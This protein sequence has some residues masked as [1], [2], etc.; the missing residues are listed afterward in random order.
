[1]C[2]IITKNVVMYIWCIFESSTYLV[3]RVT[4]SSRRGDTY[5]VANDNFCSYKVTNSQN[6]WRST[7]LVT[8]CFSYR[9]WLT[10]SWWADQTPTV[11]KMLIDSCSPSVDQ[12]R[13][14]WLCPLNE[15]QAAMIGCSCLSLLMSRTP[16]QSAHIHPFWIPIPPVIVN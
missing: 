3:S 5:V 16:F 9:Q 1:M 6:T 2:D 14:L 13:Q 7:F 8:M 12:I 11:R 10:L 4:N 15:N